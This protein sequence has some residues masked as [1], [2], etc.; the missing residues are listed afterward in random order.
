MYDFDLMTDRKGTLSYKWD[1]KD[2]ELPMW[3]ADMDFE[4]VPEAK[5]AIVKRAEHGIFGYT[6]TPDEYFEAVS[7]YFGRRHGFKI[8]TEWMVYSNGIIAAIG[9][10]IRKLTTPAENVLI[11]APVYNIFYNSI[12]NNGRN[13]LSS[14]L[15]YKDGEYSIDFADLEEKLARPQ[16]SMMILCNPHNPVGR[17]WTRDELVRIGELCKKHGVTVIS[18]EIHCDFVAKGK[19]YTPF[20]SAS[21]VCGD[22]SITC[23]SSSKTF[24]LAGLQSACVYAKNPFIRH[25]VYRGLNTEELGEPNAFSM[26]ANI[27]A[28][29][30]GDRW[31]EELC[32]YIF[33]NKRYAEKYIKENIPE[34]YPVHSDATYLLWVDVSGIMADSV[35]FCKRLRELTGLYISDGLEYGECSRSFVRI[36]M[37]TQRARVLDGLDRL[38]RGINM[39]LAE[40]AHG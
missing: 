31:I 8:P 23:V 38:K 11:Q 6:A 25:K 40:R 30:H 2:G 3:V 7:G 29:N 32:D 16:T 17:V 5:E 9:S 34:L 39:I 14:N 18:D 10:I 12:L 19:K 24:N 37:A 36:N 13:V 1:V 20:A 26:Q 35:L 33:D 21:D 15:V 22:I 4:T 28:F 27:A